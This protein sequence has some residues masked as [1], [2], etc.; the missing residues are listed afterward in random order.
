[1]IFDDCLSAV[2]AHTAKHLYEFC[3][4]GPL[5]RD[6]TVILVTHHVGLCIKGAAYVVLMSDGEVKAAG[7]P[8][9]MVKSGV[10]GDELAR[11]EEQRS[12]EKEEAVTDGPIPTVP[13]KLQKKQQDGAGKLTKEEER[14]EGSV[15]WSVYQTY[16]SA[17][18]GWLFWVLV[19]ILFAATQGIVLGQD[20]WIKVWAAAY[21]DKA[22]SDSVGAFATTTSGTSELGMFGI[23]YL[24]P[25]ADI[26]AK[27]EVDVKYYLVIYF[28]IGVVALIMSS[29]RS[30]ILFIGSLN[31]SRRIHAQLLEKILRAK[32]RFYD[33]TPIGRIVN[34]FSSD[35]ETID[36]A[37][38]PTLS[39]LLFSIVNMFCVIVLV[40]VITPTFVVPGV[41]I[42]ILYW[43]IGSYY[44][45]TS[46]D[47]K[48][49]N[50]VTRSPIYVQFNE[51]VNGVM[52]IRAY[53][54][55]QRFLNENY[56]RVD[57][58]NRPFIWMWATNRWLHARVET[59]G[60]FVGFCT[61]FVLVMS[62]DWVDPGLAGLSLSYALTFTHHVLWVIRMYAVNEMNLVCLS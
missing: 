30:L 11:A 9:A 32:V 29:L 36:Q 39:F 28:L 56:D 15:S 44:L 20:Y 41:I 26:M 34:R 61:G 53:G 1:M 7:E 60:A 21:S 48:R 55:Q 38:A 10:L 2:D 16:L 5:M 13:K 35:M 46:R 54:C 8:R 25:F 42:A 50:S 33:T 19:V 62:R 40:T 17:S 45:A 23:T 51:S 31:A 58:N 22:P 27:Q 37:I 24:R 43:L 52:T 14:A 12:D 6:R 18:G 57:S 47:L 49:L 4:T 3:L 59:L